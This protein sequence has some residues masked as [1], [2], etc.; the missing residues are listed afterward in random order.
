[1][2]V[3]TNGEFIAIRQVERFK[4]AL[5]AAVIGF[6]C[7][8]DGVNHQV[9]VHALVLIER[10]LRVAV[11]V[12]GAGRENFDD[13][14]GR[15]C[16]VPFRNIAAQEEHIRADDGV[17]RNDPVDILKNRS[18]RLCR[19]DRR[20]KC[21]GN[22]EGTMLMGSKG[23]RRH[24]DRNALPKFPVPVPLRIVGKGVVRDV[25]ACRAHGFLMGKIGT[26]FSQS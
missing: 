26:D 18:L 7:L 22:P 12:S 17:V 23:A 8:G 11:P 9:V 16:H 14:R 25:S 4:T 5:V 19:F 21:S 20:P 3:F 2:A 1:L 13:E 10:E 24:R 6:E 15:L